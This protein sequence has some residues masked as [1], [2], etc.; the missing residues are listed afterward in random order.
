MKPG[1]IDYLPFEVR[2][3]R[4]E[5]GWAHNP[6]L[7]TDPIT[8]I[9]WVGI[10]RHDLLPLTVHLEPDSPHA[11]EP[12]F[13]EVGQFDTD[14]LTPREFKRVHPEP[15]SPPFIHSNNVEDV[16]V[17]HRPDGLH[18]IGVGFPGGKITQVEILI[19]YDKGTYKLLRDYGQPAGRSEKNW[20]APSVPTELFDFVYSPTEVVRHG[21]PRGPVYTG[22]VHGGSQLLPYKDGWIGVSHRIVNVTDLT[23]RWYVSL[24]QLYDKY[25]TVTHQSQFFDFGTGWR[26]NLQE[27]VEFVSGAIWSK[28]EEEMILSLGVKDEMCGFVRVPVSAFNWQPADSWYKDFSLHPDLEKIVKSHKKNA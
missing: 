9:T 13:F 18:G 7:S 11:G 19:D 21:R 27:S 2:V 23:P 15:D 1:F 14:T 26:E 16:R 28:P 3:Y 6:T 20:Q 4:P 24:A 22:S 25:G 10:R 8:G 12:S 17:F 5:K